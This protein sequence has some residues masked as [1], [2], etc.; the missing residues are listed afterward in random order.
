MNCAI[1]NREALL[2]AVKRV[3]AAVDK[4]QTM[5]VLSH[6]LLTVYLRNA[7]EVVATDL[8]VCA[9]AEVVAAVEEGGFQACVPAVRFAEAL[10]ALT[11]E[12]ATVILEG[13]DKLLLVA[14]PCRYE[15]ALLP[16]DEFP[17]G[18]APGDPLLSFAPGLLPRLFNAV[19][20]AASTDATKYHLGGAF[21]ARDQGRILAVATDGHRLSITA[22]D[23]P[24]AVELG[25]KGF[26]LPAK[27][28]RLLAGAVGTLELS[29]SGSEVV[30]DSADYRVTS[31]L[32]EG[33]YP[34]F[35]RVIP[36]NLTELIIVD[37]L[38]FVAAVTACGVVADDK[39]KSV[40]L[41]SWAGSGE[42]ALSTLGAT[43]ACFACLP[44]TAE[45]SLEL[46]MRFDGRYLLDALK[47][48][49]GGKVWLRYGAQGCPL[50]LLPADM[51]GFDERVEVL[52]PMRSGS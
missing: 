16:A 51:S 19:K 15:F 14:G 8:E 27:T 49:P 26:I 30:F 18:L 9:C 37:R 41:Q 43:G 11:A 28:M 4:K 39:N 10:D 1:V 25:T 24:E 47:S 6:L 3:C 48:L 31:R 23:H 34:D 40:L 33:D 36:A 13:T 21:L 46:N 17:Q 32:L 5:P 52:M 29:R 50:L 7:L 44:S 22:V 12:E 35:R 2:G 42:L 38:A 45:H 20:H